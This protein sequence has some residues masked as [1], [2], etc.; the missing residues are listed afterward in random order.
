MAHLYKNQKPWHE[1]VGQKIKTVSKYAAM[2]KGAFDVGKSI[3]EF[4][5]TVAPY[6]A[7]AV[8]AL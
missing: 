5:S 7:T 6:I 4:G 1:A 3:Y 2:A 8:A